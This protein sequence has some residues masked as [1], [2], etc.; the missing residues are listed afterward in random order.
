MFC[1]KQPGITG[2]RVFGYR[3]KHH[4]LVGHLQ[5]CVGAITASADTVVAMS[6]SARAFTRAQAYSTIVD[7]RNSQ[8]SSAQSIHVSATSASGA[9]PQRQWSLADALTD[10]SGRLFGWRT[11]WRGPATYAAAGVVPFA[12]RED[13][14]QLYV[15]LSI[16]R[17]DRG[18]GPSL[19]YTFLGGK[20]AGVDR[21]DARRTAAREAHEETHRLLVEQ[22]VLD[23]LLG[24]VP[25]YDS[26]RA[27]AAA[28]AATPGPN[29]VAASAASPTASSSNLAGA[30]MPASDGAF[31]AA[32]TVATT[33]AA[34]VATG[35]TAAAEVFAGNDAVETSSSSTDGGASGRNLRD[36]D[37][38]QIDGSRSDTGIGA[39]S[40]T[41]EASSLSGCARGG[42]Y[43]VPSEYFSSGRYMAFAMHLPDSWHLPGGC[44]AM[45]KAKQKHPEAEKAE[46]LEWIT[47]RQLGKLRENR[48]LQ[49][50]ISGCA[51]RG[52]HYML[53]LLRVKRD[54]V[55][56]FTWLKR[57][58][59]HLRAWHGLP[60]E[61]EGAEAME[62][63]TEGRKTR[64]NNGGGAKAREKGKG[65]AVGEA[66]AK[67][68]EE[69]GEEGA[70]EDESDSE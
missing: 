31:S 15:L 50:S 24:T 41:A 9:T 16:Q 40:S 32:S 61:H 48:C 47:L 58:E 37:G 21:K 70:S 25:A 59:R 30:A 51:V 57:L 20:V 2:N 44:T 46:G 12:Y 42:Q 56:V 13:E 66:A 14:G 45:I 7:E 6:R 29:A 34:V 1:H 38:A 35:S 22:T 64:G 54:T 10:K 3:T 5:I 18:R 28:A 26:T 8:I 23:A 63:V 36:S 4:S 39:S 55:G 68:K 60:E 62:A 33:T 52:H 49:D 53:S 43:P 65:A 11:D 19:V 17:S 69:E 27:A 67:A